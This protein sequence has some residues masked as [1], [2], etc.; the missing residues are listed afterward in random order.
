MADSLT[1]NVPEDFDLNLLVEK[2]KN[3][4][5]MQG[6]TITAAALQPNSHRIVFDKNCGGINMLLGLGQGITA[7]LTLNGNCLFVNY[8]DGDWTGK[9]IG[10]VAGWILCLVPFI[11]ALV[12]CCNQFNLPKK[13]SND[14][15]M[16]ISSMTQTNT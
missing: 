9:I 2:I 3:N 13:I 4:F 16:L 10:L 15:T 5:Q 7:T 6:F 1:I 8:S 14:I 12:G 11:T